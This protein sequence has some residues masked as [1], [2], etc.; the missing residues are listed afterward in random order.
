MFLPL[1]P[2][3]SVRAPRDSG[4]VLDTFDPSDS[5]G[6]RAGTSARLEWEARRGAGTLDTSPDGPSFE[7]SRLRGNREVVKFEDRHL[8]Q[9]DEIEQLRV[10]ARSIMKAANSNARAEYAARIAPG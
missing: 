2:I 9:A 10:A 1:S 3:S 7:V 6:T 8:T 5:A 4:L